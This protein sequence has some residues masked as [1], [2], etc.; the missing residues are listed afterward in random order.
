MQLRILGGALQGRALIRLPG[1]VR[2]TQSRIRRAIFDALGSSVEGARVLDLFAGSGA[3]G[4]EALSRGAEKVVLVERNRA[5][6][7]RLRDLVRA[8]GVVDRVRV[9]AADV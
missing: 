9:V 4:L 3:L 6:T 8:W 5:L 2:P 7:R 1:D